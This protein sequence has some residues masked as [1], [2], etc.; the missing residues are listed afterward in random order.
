MESCIYL[1]AST[2]PLLSRARGAG[3]RK[4]AGVGGGPKGGTCFHSKFRD[5]GANVDEN[6]G[7]RNLGS[8]TLRA[9]QRRPC[10]A[11]AKV[12][13]CLK[14]KEK[15]MSKCGDPTRGGTT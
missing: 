3:I 1:D 4:Q 14:N 13:K 9:Y 6:E 5:M 10:H 15:E 11:G 2:E 12:V 7:S 8:P